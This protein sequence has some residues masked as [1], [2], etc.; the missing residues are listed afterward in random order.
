MPTQRNE[1]ETRKKNG[2]NLMNSKIDLPTLADIQE[3]K[4]PSM[5][6]GSKAVKEYFKYKESLK[7]SF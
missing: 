3:S 2:K 4:I 7:L 1:K 5:L 6:K